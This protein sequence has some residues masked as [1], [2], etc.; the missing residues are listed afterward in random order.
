MLQDRSINNT[1]LCPAYRRKKYVLFL[2]RTFCLTALY[3]LLW[4]VYLI[5]FTLLLSVPFVTLYF[6]SLVGWRYFME[7]KIQRMRE[8]IG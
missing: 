7:R 4:D 8:G 6:F 3:V 1:M 2:L 5:R